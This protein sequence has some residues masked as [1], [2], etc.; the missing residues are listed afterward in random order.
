MKCF[1]TLIVVIIIIA[2]FAWFGVYFPR[3]LGSKETPSFLVKKGQG[4][5]EISINLEEQGLI[6]WG[7]LFRIYIL[8]KGTAGDLKAG[9]YSFSKTMTIP[10]IVN[11]LVSGEVVK[12]KI[13]IIEGW[14]LR[15]ISEYLGEEIEPGLEG[16]LF[17]DTYEISPEADIEEIIN[18]MLAN[19][20]KK[21]NQDLREEIISQGKSI[22]EIVT[23]ASLIEKEVRTPED[24]KIVSGI[25]WKRLKNNIPLQVDA[26]IA[27]IT[28]KKT[29]KISREETQIDSPYN[30][31]KYKG[32][33]LGPICSPGL[34]SITAAIY[35]ELS[36]YWFYLS[37]PEGQT[38]FSKTLEEHNIAKAKYLK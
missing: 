12:N 31:Y 7:P 6:W 16:Y 9:E 4:A 14:N 3:E 23:M 27:Y 35:P 24:K 37:I 29:T 21:L 11:K 5:K 26:T 36:S 32:L 8:L 19:F 38:I 30:T 17:P 25:L 18:K 34:E 22:F 33:P 28:G 1:I 2:I 15:D 10:E 20:D 13:T